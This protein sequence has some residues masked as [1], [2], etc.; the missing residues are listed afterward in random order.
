M[1][2]ILRINTSSSQLKSATSLLEDVSN[3][4]SLCP[5]DYF[6]VALQPG[7]RTM[8][9]STHES[10]PRLRQMLMGEDK[11]IQ[12]NFTVAEVFGELD[13]AYLRTLLQEKCGLQLTEIDASSKLLQDMG[14]PRIQGLRSPQ[15]RL[16]LLSLERNLK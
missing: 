15:L 9:Y 12:S 10:A 11:A 2:F 4:L 3:K 1:R 14:D 16:Y 7:V 6:V 5:S 8:D 13:P